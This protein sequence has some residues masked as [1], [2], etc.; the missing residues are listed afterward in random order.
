MSTRLVLTNSSNSENHNLAEKDT[1]GAT[2]YHKASTGHAASGRR[3]GDTKSDDG[4]T[5]VCFKDLITLAGRLNNAIFNDH[6]CLT[7]I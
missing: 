7:R 4:A 5:V 6:A 1:L 2:W 3:D